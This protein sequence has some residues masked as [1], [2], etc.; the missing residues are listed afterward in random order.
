[1]LAAGC[2]PPPDVATTQ[3][4]AK[5]PAGKYAPGVIEVRPQ[6]QALR[7]LRVL[8]G[9]GGPRGHGR[10]GGTSGEDHGI[11]TQFQPLARGGGGADE[12]GSREGRSGRM[13]AAGW[14][15]PLAR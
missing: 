11:P 3:P 1:M 13:A 8:V 7:A 2:P 4:A 12:V 9:R 15:R 5:R 6:H 14:L 10:K